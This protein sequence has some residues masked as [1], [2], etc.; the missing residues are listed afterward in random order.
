VNMY[1]D[2]YMHEIISLEIVKPSEQTFKALIN[3]G[4]RGG[5]ILLFTEPIGRQEFDN[6]DFLKRH[7][8]IPAKHEQTILWK[9][10]EKNG[11]VSQEMYTKALQWRGLILPQDPQKAADFILWALKTKLLFQMMHKKE[12]N[13][14]D[15]ELSPYGVELFW[16]KVKKFMEERER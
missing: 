6:L 3:P 2:T 10:A 16:K 7:K 1:E 11:D 4:R 13:I 8:L 9:E 5:V 14:D 12:E 15:K